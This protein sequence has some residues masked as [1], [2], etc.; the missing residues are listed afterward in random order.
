MLEG[1]IQIA[2]AFGCCFVAASLN[3]ATES[4]CARVLLLLLLLLSCFAVVQPSKREQTL[5]A[6]ATCALQI[7]SQSN[8]QLLR[9]HEVAAAAASAA[10]KLLWGRDLFCALCILRSSACNAHKAQCARAA[11]NLASKRTRFEE[12]EKEKNTQRAIWHLILSRELQQEKRSIELRA[13]QQ[14]ASVGNTLVCMRN[15]LEL[16][17]CVCDQSVFVAASLEEEAKQVGCKWSPKRPICHHRLFPCFKLSARA[18]CVLCA[19][20]CVCVGARLLSAR[21]MTSCWRPHK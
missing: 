3:F 12:R 2:L 6:R 16:C 20:C 7:R 1:A 13:R 18:C 5:D 15:P 17:V 11:R 4:V 21:L 9:N 10:A 14:S 8:V 19:V